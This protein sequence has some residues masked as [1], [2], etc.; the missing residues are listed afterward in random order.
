MRRRV[1]WVS[2][3]NIKHRV[4]SN[5]PRKLNSFHNSVV[6]LRNILSLFHIPNLIMHYSGLVANQIF[7][8]L[9]NVFLL[10]FE[11]RSPIARLSMVTLWG[12][13]LMVSLSPRGRNKLSFNRRA[14]NIMH[15]VS[16]SW[17]SVNL[18]HLQ[19]L[20]F[21]NFFQKLLNRFL[22]KLSGLEKANF[23]LHKLRPWWRW[24][25]SSVHSC[26]FLLAAHISFLNELLTFFRQSLSF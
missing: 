12:I 11:L 15:L 4:I 3:N 20:S 16:G 1:H 18:L 23:F 5:F 10:R 17:R 14:N 19:S 7:I 21:F 25:Q 6:D 24:A 22:L 26:L 8:K 13:L 2:N 9:L